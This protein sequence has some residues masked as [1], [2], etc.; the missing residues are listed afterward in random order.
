MLNSSFELFLVIPS[1]A[2]E[3]SPLVL[4]LSQLNVHNPNTSCQTLTDVFIDHI[5]N[6][7]PKHHCISQK[8]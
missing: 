5:V 7:P 2:T 6:K 1:T 3:L 4:H 8:S